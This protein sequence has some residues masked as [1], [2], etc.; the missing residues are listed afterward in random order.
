MLYAET[1]VRPIQ[2]ILIAELVKFSTH[3][4]TYIIW[5]ASVKTEDSILH[6][7]AHSETHVAT[8]HIYQHVFQR[9][10]QHTGLNAQIHL[11]LPN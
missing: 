10:P 6:A 4:L 9:V 7:E 11:N 1:H 2:A 8:L 5:V 3:S